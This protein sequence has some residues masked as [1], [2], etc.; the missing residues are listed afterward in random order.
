MHHT[1]VPDGHPAMGPLSPKVKATAKAPTTAYRHSQLGDSTAAAL[2]GDNDDGYVIKDLQLPKG[3]FCLGRLRA[4]WQGL[5]LLHGSLRTTYNHDGLS[6]NRSVSEILEPLRFGCLSHD[7]PDGSQTGNNNTQAAY[8]NVCGCENN[9]TVQLVV[10]QS[11]VDEE[12]LQLMQTDFLRLYS[13]VIPTTTK[14]EVSNR[15]TK[16]SAKLAHGFWKAQFQGLVETPIYTLEVECRNVTRTYGSIHSSFD[17]DAGHVIT[18]ALRDHPELSIRE[19]ALAAWATC[20]SWH[21]DAGDR[22]VCFATERSNPRT[23]CRTY[24]LRIPLGDDKTAASTQLREISNLDDEAFRHAY[25]GYDEISSLQESGGPKIYSKVITQNSCD[26]TPSLE[27]NSSHDKLVFPLTITVGQD[28][29]NNDGRCR[30]SLQHDLSIPRAK[31]V[32]LLKHFETA[33]INTASSYNRGVNWIDIP[34][35]GGSEHQFLL[36]L[37]KPATEP[38]NGIIHH[39]F[40]KQVLKTPDNDAVQFENES[41]LTYAQLNKLAN[42]VARQLG[43]GR[44]DYVPVCMLRSVNLIVAILAILKSG[45]AYVPLDPDVPEERNHF[46]VSDVSSSFVLCDSYSET[47][48]PNP[49]NIEALANIN[50]AHLRDGSNLGVMQEPT[51]IC[52]VIYTS[53]STGNPKGVLLEH[54]AAYSGLAAF[55]VLPQLRQLFFHNPVFS[56]AQRSVWSTLEQGGCLCM[57]SKPNLTVFIGETIEQMQINVIDVTPS[58]AALITPGTTPSLKRMTVAGELINPA[59]VPPWVHRL[60]LLNAYGLSENTQFNW[61]HVIQPGQ[62]P[63]NIGRP[64][65]TT[66]AYV[67]RPGTTELCPLLVPGEL[68]LGGHQLAREYLNRPEKTREAFIPNP[69]GQGRLY[70][71]GDM[72]VTH[73]DGSIEMVGRLDFQVKINDQRVEPGE[74]NSLI[75]MHEDVFDSSVVSARVGDKKSL[76]A[77]VVPVRSPTSD[78]QK[79]RDGLKRHVT[80]QLPLYMAP[81][82]WI[83]LDSLPLNVNGKVDVPALRSQVEGFGRDGLRRRERAQPPEQ[84]KGAVE[85][86][87][88]SLWADVLS[89]DKENIRSSDTFLDFGGSSLEAIKVSSRA[90]KI[91]IDIS[92]PDILQGGSLKDVSSLIRIPNNNNNNTT[93]TGL[94]VP[95]PFALAGRYSAEDFVGADDAYPA[96]A[97][98]Q[99]IIADHITGTGRYA[100]HRAYDLG[101]VTPDLFKEAFRKAIHLSPIYRSVFKGRGRRIF[102]VVMRSLDVPFRSFEGG[103]DLYLETKRDSGHAFGFG[104]PMI[105]VV[106]IDGQIAVVIMHHALFDFWSHDFSI[107]DTRALLQGRT[108]TARPPFSAYMHHVAA[109]NQAESEQFWCEYLSGVYS[110]NQ[111]PTSSVDSGFN[112]ST[113]LEVA[114]LPV[115]TKH[116]VTLPSLVYAAWAATIAKYTGK[117]DVVFLIMLSGRDAPIADVDAMAGPTLTSVPLRITVE[118][119][120]TLVDIARAVASDLWRLAK[121]AYIG[122]NQILTAAGIPNPPNASMVNFLLSSGTIAQDPEVLQPIAI[123]QS[124]STGQLVLEVED[125]SLRL[126]STVGYTLAQGMLDDIQMMLEDLCNDTPSTVIRLHQLAVDSTT[127]D[128]PATNSDESPAAS[129]SSAESAPFSMSQDLPD[130]VEAIMKASGINLVTAICSVWALVVSY[131]A[132]EDRGEFYIQRSNGPTAVSVLLSVDI[133]S[134]E[135]LDGLIRSVENLMMAPESEQITA[136]ATPYDLAVF[137]D[138]DWNDNA[139]KDCTAIRI[140]NPASTKTCLHAESNLDEATFAALFEELCTLLSFCTSEKIKLPL[141]ELNFVGPME[142]KMLRELSETVDAERSTIHSRFEK[143]AYGQPHLEAIQWED[144]DPLTYGD[145]DYEAEILARHLSQL[146][147][148]PGVP[149]PGVP[150]PICMDKSPL[151]VKCMLAV[152]KAGGLFVPLDPETPFDRNNFI[153]KE[154]GAPIVL[155]QSHLKPSVEMFEVMPVFV[156]V[157]DIIRRDVRLVG[158]PTEI[159]PDS[160][161]YMIYTSG[162]TGGAPKGVRVS[163]SAASSAVKSMIAAEDRYNGNWRCLQFANYV[164]DASVQDI[165]NTLCSGGCLCMTTKD[166]MMSNLESVI[167]DLSISRA[168]LTPTVARLL[169]PEKVPTMETMIVGGEAMTPEVIRKWSSKKLLNV[170]GPTETSMVVSTKHV[171]SDAE[172][173]NVGKPFRTAG[174]LIVKPRSRRLV[175]FG[176]VGEICVVGPQVS[177]GYLNRPE[178]NTTA[179]QPSVLSE[180]AVMYRTGDLG[181]W[182]PSNEI[183][184]LGRIDTQ[185]KVAGHRIELQEIEDVIRKTGIAEDCIVD[186]ASIGGRSCLVAFCAFRLG[187]GTD[188]VSEPVIGNEELESIK[189]LR[190]SLGMLASYMKPKY[191]LPIS[192]FP[193]LPSQKVDRRKLRELAESLDVNTLSSCAFETAGLLPMHSAPGA[194]PTSPQEKAIQ[195]VWADV[196][197]VDASVLNLKTNFFSLGGDSIAAINTVALCR[198]LGWTLSVKELLASATLEAAAAKM[199]PVDGSTETTNDFEPPALIRCLSRNGIYGGGSHVEH[200]FP[201]PPGQ[202]EF[203]SQGTKED[204]LWVLLTVRDFPAT[205]DFEDWLGAVRHL[206]QQNDVLRSTFAK[207]AGKWVGAVLASAE[208]WVDYFDCDKSEKA[209]IVEVIW[210]QRFIFGMPF[211]RYALV[212][213]PDGTRD[214]IIKMD[215]GLWDGTLFRIFD[216]QFKE[217]A[218]GQQPPTIPKTSSSDFVMHHFNVDKTES[219]NHW[220]AIVDSRNPPLFHSLSSPKI[221][222]K[223]VIPIKEDFRQL[224]ESCGVTLPTIFQGVFQL[225]LSRR[226]AAA[227]NAANGLGAGTPRRHEAS[228]DYL[229]TGRNFALPEPQNVNG[230][231]ANFLPFLMRIDPDASIRSYFS[232]TQAMF[233]EA[234]E[235]GYVGLDEI[236]NAAGQNRDDHGNRTM[237]LYQPF[238]PAAPAQQDV[239]TMDKYGYVVL[240]KSEVT[241]NQPYGLIV[242]VAKTTVGFVFKVMWDHRVFDEKAAMDLG[243]NMIET[244]RLLSDASVEDTAIGRFI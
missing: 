187:T 49:V 85:D 205:F 36:D 69:F 97:L 136:S 33:L 20:M 182:L 198:S 217:I 94:H 125:R 203:L 120:S 173:R 204:Q 163:H 221:T 1:D 167:N 99:A 139:L 44:G 222:Q 121:H 78:W 37:G 175:P 18:S 199:T 60:E 104:D 132:G 54:R 126:M 30:C 14:S 129:L 4:S 150:T 228:Y 230:N 189:T 200:F 9:A 108:P 231:C 165:F 102:Q 229:L 25:I 116:G 68:C 3:D 233:W 133:D 168:I 195:N 56:A 151:A 86:S 17:L 113:P 156:D 26:Q 52:Y 76:V 117:S 141:S 83:A 237:F 5:S 67:L 232:S 115:V 119:D 193:K 131:R 51:D 212:R 160:I 24:P 215:H 63:Q 236:Y 158:L 152:L 171:L 91:G 80:A 216:G 172:P 93:V 225:W 15:E 220:K 164:F 107:E 75:Q 38:A 43:C 110:L 89:I 96:T 177:S 194:N 123:P 166:R 39:L 179:Y 100:Y 12:T 157:L 28:N 92:V 243:E 181:K 95:K 16:N 184:C 62:N 192:V 162:S 21:T 53:G 45:A 122:A 148:S 64:I 178:L 153:I 161:A 77:A 186:V 138:T 88:A 211:V 159:S 134:S 190:E 2:T 118:N 207:V 81:A 48:V 210:N 191:V 112:I 224:S 82:F 7:T 73:E 106:I 41:P 70:R 143:L 27:K 59:L 169:N 218:S 170:Y 149:T 71:T 74:V 127:D 226:A 90:R 201:C 180:E 98:Q 128:T 197:E 13:G 61:R 72:V 145:L 213:Y 6:W 40:E 29:N 65:D 223:L 50:S 146:G 19:L 101:S 42:G 31:A 140:E 103:L 142:N 240:S 206:T 79:L 8:V 66:T 111:L 185:V 114:L 227:A 155:T 135:S 124:P 11:L 219:L 176:A 238:E 202:S 144:D 209:S 242:E 47:K 147:V 239:G 241:M 154:S 23:G 130:G 55:P 22:T 208:P 58:T 10:H 84:A 214:L 57:A 234:T 35:L 105:E 109:Q 137:F 32:L 46:I 196:F 34:V 87:V 235:H 244:M 174:V 188:I 183:L